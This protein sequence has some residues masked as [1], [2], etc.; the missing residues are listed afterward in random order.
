M[1]EDSDAAGAQQ[2]SSPVGKLKLL[3][4]LSRTP[5]GALDLATP[6]MAALLVLGHFPDTWIIILGLITAFAGYT[7]VYALNDLVDYQI[8]K[9]RLALSDHEKDFH[10]VDEIT[11]RHPMAA[12]AL[13]YGLGVAWFLFWSIIALIGAYLLN[14]LCAVLFL[15]SA[16][17]EAIYCKLLKITHW[18]IVPSA[19]VKASGGLAGVYAVDHDPSISF[20]MVLFVWLAAWEVGAQ[21]IANDIV[22]M[23]DDSKVQAKTTSTVKG[24]NESIFRA[25]SAVS[26]ASLAG[27]LIYGF[28]GDGVGILY[29]IGATIISWYLLLSPARELFHRADV[30]AAA[31]LFNKGSYLPVSFL[32]LTVLAIGLK[33]LQ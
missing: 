5:H 16:S 30:K 24:I 25:V 26:M 21:N 17:L 33:W 10:H 3:F 1:T 31:N 6:A 12:G 18:K 13:S 9:K 14:P 23:E 7:A 32:V 11:I 8:D 27:V 22:D 2:D 19:I 20:V 29:P 15:I 28:A 4:G